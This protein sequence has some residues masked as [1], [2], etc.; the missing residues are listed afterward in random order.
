MTGADG[1]V[2][3]TVPV[4]YEIIR[5]W[6]TQPGRVGMFAQ[7]WPEKQQ[8]GGQIP[9]RFRFTLEPGTEIGGFVKNEQGQPIAGVRWKFKEQVSAA[10]RLAIATRMKPDAF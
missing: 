10:S 2:A 6:A 1:I 7:W 8:D 9:N 3:I 5:L 4:E